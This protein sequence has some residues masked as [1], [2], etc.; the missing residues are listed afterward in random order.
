M[1]DDTLF[2]PD[3]GWSLAPVATWMYTAGRRIS[4]PMRM[5]ESLA[6]QLNDAGAHIDRMAV[7]SRT[8]HPQLVGWSVYW[9][10]QSGARRDNF[11]YST[12][13]SD[14]YIGSPIEQVQDHQA[15]VR[16]HIGP[17]PVEGEH[18]LIPDLRAEGITDYV[19]LP[20]IS[21]AG[22]VHALTLATAAQE[23]FTPDDAA[24]PEGVR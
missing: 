15:T 19:A 18:G 20:M 6:G 5:I 2:G 24:L 11:E 3:A 4:D 16:L 14:A 13:A 23:L 1:S 17:Q 9:S 21:G 22:T 7:M 10:R 8:L 12:R